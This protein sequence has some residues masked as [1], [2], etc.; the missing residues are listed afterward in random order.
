MSVRGTTFPAVFMRGGTSKG[1]FFRAGVLPDDPALRDRILLAVLGSPDPYNRQIDGLGGASSSTSKAVIVGPSQRADADV[2]YL[3]AQV[4]VDRAV[5]D[6]SGNC[7]NLSGAV[8]PFAISQGMVEPVEGITVVRI[9]Q[10]NTNRLI[11]AHVPVHDGE[12]LEE[13]DFRLDGVPSPGA[14]IEVDFV[15]PG[16]SLTGALL[17]TGNAVDEL[18]V[19]G[20]GRVRATL[21]DAATAMVFVAAGDLGLTGTELRGDVDRDA[22]L[23]RKL[24]AIRAHAAVAMGLAGSAEDATARRPATPKIAF[25]SPPQAHVASNGAA[26]GAGDVDF[27]ARVLSMGTLH[28]AYVATGAVATA[29][30]AV[31]PGTVVNAVSPFGGDG[32]ASVRFAH[33]SGV[34]RIGAS[35]ERS[36]G[37]WRARNVRVSRT[38]RRIMAGDVYV[39]SWALAGAVGATGTST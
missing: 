4:S 3:F 31:L 26:I 18:D 39:P 32:A 19:P 27:V 24:E 7:G 25:V 11:V 5:V 23:L 8:G 9:W 1:V 17:P 20:I 2:D 21:L 15:D 14:E 22:A 30:A 6:T 28:H 37:A 38:A 36:G 35:V 12:P 29:V 13:G 16:G 33:P 10:V 34:V